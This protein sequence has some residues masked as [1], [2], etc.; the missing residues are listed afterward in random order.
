MARKKK[1]RRS[2]KEKPEGQSKYA[3]KIRRRKRICRELE[4]PDTPFPVLWAQ[5][6]NDD[7]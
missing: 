5:E 1:I 4:I 7:E 2:M 6:N 3:R